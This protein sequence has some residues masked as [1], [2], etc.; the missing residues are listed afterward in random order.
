MTDR[1]YPPHGPYTIKGKVQSRMTGEANL[2]AEKV[3]RWISP[4]ELITQKT[5]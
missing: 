2:I 4:R 1:L 5:Y 3:H